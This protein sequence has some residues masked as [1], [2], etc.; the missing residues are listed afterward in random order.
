MRRYFFILGSI[1]LFLFLIASAVFLATHNVIKESEG[2]ASHFQ[3][4]SEVNRPTQEKTLNKNVS[5]VFLG[6]MMF[7]RY[8][9]EMAQ[10][11][12]YGALLRDPENVLKKVI[13][14]WVIL[15]GP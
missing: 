1:L 5:I 2:V 4:L 3:I 9:R 6:D 15:K 13:Q 7:D 12:G 11:K 14:L 10:N 8:I